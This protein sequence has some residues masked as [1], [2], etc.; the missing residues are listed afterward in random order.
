MEIGVLR[1]NTSYHFGY[2]I[3]AS[4]T[5]TETPWIVFSCGNEGI[6]YMYNVNECDSIADENINKCYIDTSAK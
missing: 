4:V 2:I 1:Y 5:V 3:G 6:K